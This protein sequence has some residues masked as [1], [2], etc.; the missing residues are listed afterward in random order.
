M[1]EVAY[2]TIPAGMSKTLSA[3]PLGIEDYGILARQLDTL[4]ASL[5]NN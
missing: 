2:S 1:E 3:C 5:K 4:I